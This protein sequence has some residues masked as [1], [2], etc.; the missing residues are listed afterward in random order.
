MADPLYPFLKFCVTT[1]D[2][3]GLHETKDYVR[4]GDVILCFEV[5]GSCHGG[6]RYVVRRMIELG[7]KQ[8]APCT[9]HSQNE[10]N[11]APRFRDVG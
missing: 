8:L 3:N 4:C 9:V 10:K 1:S 11:T 7:M 2:V 6:G 5:I